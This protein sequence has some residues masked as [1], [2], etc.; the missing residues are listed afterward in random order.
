MV[1]DGDSNTSTAVPPE[2][3]F[4]MLTDELRIEI[5]RALGHTPGYTASFSMLQERVGIADS[6]LF[7][8]HLQKL[9]D[10]FIRHT[11]DGYSLRYAGRLVYRA[12][13]AGIFTERYQEAPIQLQERCPS[14][15]TRLESS[16]ADGRHRVT[17][18]D[19]RSVFHMS[20]LHPA[21]LDSRTLSEVLEASDRIARHGIAL[22]VDGVC[23]H[24]SSI[25]TPTIVTDPVQSFGQPFVEFVCENCGLIASANVG[26][27]LL[28]HPVVVSFFH[29]HGV[30]LRTVR[31]W[32][33]AFC[34]D[35]E[36]LT[37]R[38]EDPWRITV[39]I[40]RDDEELQITVD[41]DLNVI[42]RDRHHH[43]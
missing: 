6:G 24:C 5:I 20:A 21:G 4:S 8:Y 42:E 3:A 16:Y 37:V 2:T 35:D 36:Y 23:M 40:P 25:V 15:E 28:P 43:S 11:E 39:P 19:C 13:E 14:C 10:H 33:L 22:A 29:D 32:E 26:E 7:N 31:T 34:I 27:T 1:E 9:T 12:I 30:N 17:C 18:P 41:S 38:S